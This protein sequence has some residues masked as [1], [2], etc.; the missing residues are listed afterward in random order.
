MISF[1]IIGKNEGWRLTNCI[2]SVI[3]AIQYNELV[4]A[5]II[6][7]DSN[8]TD[9][10]IDR[11][12]QFRN[13]KIF[14]ITGKCNAAIARNIG[15]LESS[16]D[17]L[18]FIDGDME[19]ESN[20]IKLIYDDCLGLKHD[21]VSGQWLN[22]NYTNEGKF[23]SKEVYNENNY[24]DTYDYTTGGLFL[25]KK[26]LWFEVNG[27][28]TKM[29]VNEDLDIG[30]RLAKENH[31]LLRKK[32][33]LAIHHT[34]PYNDKKRIWD[35]LFSGA[36]LFR[37]VLLRE[38]IL[39][40]YGWMFFLRGNYTFFGLML[41]ILLSFI[42]LN[43]ICLLF[44]FALIIVRT[45]MRKEHSMRLIITNLFY[46]PLYETSLLFGLFLFWPKNKKLEYVSV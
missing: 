19:I 5:E 46:F 32:E 22:Y 23:I 37:I 20:F 45:V 38:N 14:L 29:K 31:F 12:K 28:K 1:I 39:N 3:N 35:L 26:V 7:V 18:F 21:F 16:N 17:I 2:K 30:L 36:Q 11:A 8:S 42:F 34:V 6:Y 43:P 25:I 24:T 9:D 15:A 10:S 33:L 44:Y 41:S 13:V 4:N 40:K 27:M